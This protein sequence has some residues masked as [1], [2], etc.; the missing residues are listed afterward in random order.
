[1]ESAR[2]IYLNEERDRNIM[3]SAMGSPH[4]LIV[5]DFPRCEVAAEVTDDFDLKFVLKYL[6]KRA[7]TDPEL[8]NGLID[9]AI[10]LS[11]DK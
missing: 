11:Q 6:K 1:M 3:L 4:L 7:A 2:V 5:Y 10:D 8:K 9:L